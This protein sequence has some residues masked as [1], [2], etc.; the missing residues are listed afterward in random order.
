MWADARCSAA[1]HV[2]ARRKQTVVAAVL[3]IC[4]LVGI[5]PLALHSLTLTGTRA[6]SAAT[7]ASGDAPS[8]LH[9]FGF[10]LRTGLLTV[11]GAYTA[12]PL[13]ET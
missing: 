12:L 10:G 4:A 11:G 5:A 2:L 8:A 9:L 1:L 7:S 3:G 13:L 6:V